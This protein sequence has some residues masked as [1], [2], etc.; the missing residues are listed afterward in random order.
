MC[1]EFNLITRSSPSAYLSAYLSI[2]LPNYPH[3]LHTCILTFLH[4][5]II[6]HTVLIHTQTY[7]HST[8]TP[9]FRSTKISNPTAINTS[10]H[11]SLSLSLAFRLSVFHLSIFP[12]F[13]L[14]IFPSFYFSVY[15]SIYLAIQ[16]ASQPAHYLPIYLPHLSS[17]RPIYIQFTND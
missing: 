12:S 5:D 2:H 16:P 7:M 15:P 3:S 17:Y 4:T 11:V 9:I 8:Y 1:S 14:S 6:A 13:N 10:I